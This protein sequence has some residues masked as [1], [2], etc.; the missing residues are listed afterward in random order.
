VALEFC[1]NIL[2]TGSRGFIGHMLI[3]SLLNLNY[4]VRAVSRSKQNYIH[5]LPLDNYKVFTIEE[6]KSD[7]GLTDAISNVGVVIHLAA[8]VHIMNDSEPDPLTAC[9]KVNVELTK[10]LVE[11]SMKSKVKRFVFI[12]SLHVNG[13]SSFIY[14]FNEADKSNPLSPYAVSKW[15]AEQYL[16]DIA[17]KTD[18]EIVIIRPPLVYGPRVKANFLSLLKLTKTGLPLPVGLLNNK[19]SM[20]SVNNLVDFIICCIEHP[21]AVNETFLISDDNDISTRG[22]FIK[23][24]KLFDKRPLL[25]PVPP[26]ILYILGA[27]LGK[28]EIVDRLCAPLQ[29]D[30]TK[31]KTI[32]GWK[33]VQTLDDGLKETIE[34]YKQEY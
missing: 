3:Q 4:N 13:S 7:F 18:M 34:W 17:K 19:R 29:V 8:R 30:I 11:L 9:R 33:P 24:I 1:K 15:E 20:I 6:S 32:L 25:L 2:V 12:S 5:E 14:P 22:L 10:K 28:R 26:K 23:L 31:A 27:L 21:K 16:N